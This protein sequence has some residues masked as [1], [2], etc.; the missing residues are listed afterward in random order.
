MENKN[1]TITTNEGKEIFVIDSREVAEMME[2]AYTELADVEVDMPSDEDV[3]AFAAKALEEQLETEVEEESADEDLD[4]E[5][6]A[7]GL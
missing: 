4:A 5:I 6:E 1:L 2:V 7:S 3:A